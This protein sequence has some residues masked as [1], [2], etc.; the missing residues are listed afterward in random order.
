[1]RVAELRR[2]LLKAN[3]VE[4]AVKMAATVLARRIDQLPRLADDLVGAFP[5]EL[6]APLRAKLKAY[7]REMRERLW[8]DML[9]VADSAPADENGAAQNGD[10]GAFERR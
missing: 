5:Q 8:S 9:A 4:E 10:D 7:A 1:M 6:I 3:E 2:S